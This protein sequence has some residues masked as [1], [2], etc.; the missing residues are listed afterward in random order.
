[1]DTRKIK[2]GDR[3]TFIAPTLYAGRP[4]LTRVVRRIDPFHRG[5]EVG[6]HGWT[7]FLVRPSEIIEH[8][9]KEA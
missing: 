4:K 7:D 6:A 9:P 3:I 5:V 1:M 2:V 8:H